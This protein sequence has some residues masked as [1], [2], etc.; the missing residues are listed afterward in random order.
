VDCLG[1]AGVFG[2]IAFEV[3]SLH[4]NPL[5]GENVKVRQGGHC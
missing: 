1:L 2:K 5:F 4:D 3:T